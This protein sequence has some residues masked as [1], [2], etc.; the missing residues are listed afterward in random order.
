MQ[1]IFEEKKREERKIDERKDRWIA[2][3][4]VHLSV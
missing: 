1:Q 3:R 4:A 2:E